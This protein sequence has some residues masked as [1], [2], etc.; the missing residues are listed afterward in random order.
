MI[1]R[2][3]LGLAFVAASSVLYNGCTTTEKIT[4]RYQLANPV[5]TGSITVLTKDTI[6]YELENYRLTDSLLIGKGTSEKSGRRLFFDG[7]IRISDIVYIQARGTSFWKGLLVAGAVGIFGITAISS[8]SGA[9]QLYV[10]E[11][12]SGG[13]SCP[14]I[15]SWNGDRY[16]LDAEAFGIAFGKALEM[17]SCS[18]LPSLKE[19][20]SLIKIKFA[21]ERPETHYINSIRLH[22]AEVDEGAMACIDAHNTLWPIYHPSPP[23]GAV[24]QSG[25]EILKKI[26]SVDQIYWET[27]VTMISPLSNF[28]DVLD[29]SFA[30]SSSGEKGSLIITAINTDFSATVF[31]NVFEFMGDQSL[32]FMYAVENDP[33]MINTLKQWTEESSLKAFFWDGEKWITI[34]TIHPEATVT[35]FSKLIRFTIGKFTGDTIKIR[36]TG[37]ADVWKIDAVQMDWTPVKPLKSVPVQLVSAID[38]GNKEVSSALAFPDN[39]YVTLLPPEEIELTFKSIIP[40]SGKKVVYAISAQGYLYEWMPDIRDRNISSQKI[41]VPENQRIQ[42]IK[43]LVQQRSLFLTPIYAEWAQLRKK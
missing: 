8:L 41:L 17:N 28:E 16:V 38:P 14:Y 20:D 24:D 1:S 26:S 11:I 10:K 32:A 5:E 36:L 39:N 30:N 35:P 6:Q 23:I 37:L 33:E 3:I 2:I 9:D 22:A 19:K 7:T 4:H 42:Y 34:G 18:V 43:D 27:N 15:Y 25:N 21:N 13:S 12:I 40:S 29:V 31:K